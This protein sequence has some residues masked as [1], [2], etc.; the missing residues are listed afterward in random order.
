MTFLPIV[1]RELRVAAR[2]RATFWMRS[3]LGVGTI[4]LWLFLLVAG[5]RSVSSPQL[6]LQ[7]FIATGVVALL[8]CL[9]AGLFLTAD[10]LS[11]E[12]REGTLGLL[13]LTE[14]KGYDVVL[15]KLLATSLHAFYG[16]LTILPVLGLPLLMGGVTVG[17]FWRT[18]LVL[19]TTLLF[20]LAL[21]LLVSAFARESRQA[22]SATLLVLLVLT[23]VMPGIFEAERWLLKG[24]TSAFLLWP[25]P[26]FLYT[27]AFDTFFRWRGSLQF[28]HSLLTILGLAVGALVAASLCLPRAW[29][30]KA[31][32]DARRPTGWKWRLRFGDRASRSARHA[33]LE[34]NPFYW[35]ASRDQLPR[36]LAY[37]IIGALLP[38]WLCFMGGC[39]SQSAM[40]RNTCFSISLLF[41][42]GLHQIAKYLV[43]VESSR[44]LNEDRQSGALEL[45]LVTP[46]EVN[47]IPGGLRRALKH[48]FG[49]PLFLV[50]L[51][52]AGLVVVVFAGLLGMAADD[53]VLLSC[54]SAGGV[55]ALAADFYALCWVGM[56]MGLRAR[57]HNRAIFATLA[58]VLLLPWAIIFCTIFASSHRPMTNGY[59]ASLF[60]VW[61]VFVFVLDLVLAGWA[62]RALHNGLRE[63]WI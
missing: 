41:A 44:R 17:E 50:C 35:L 15:G 26:A 60:T 63:L 52:N 55:L 46:L 37:F 21:G 11:E 57:R 29:R 53:I 5:Q 24:P 34:Q 28:W 36:R 48:M 20:S 33:L 7:L 1:E 43:A 32:L 56:W 22:M 8:F 12:K 47:Q 16:L 27:R 30:E 2:R 13:F 9:L 42:F 4:L 54:L 10:C 49:G 31:K 38:L 40:T 3:L 39:F 25:S 61:F 18:T 6:G 19:V 45:L 14:L 58:R 23:G 62:K 59:V 51:T